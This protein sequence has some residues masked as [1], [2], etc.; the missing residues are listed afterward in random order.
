MGRK[1]VFEVAQPIYD[2]DGNL[3]GNVG[4]QI[5]EAAYDKLAGSVA[6]GAYRA[7]IVEEKAEPAAKDEPMPEPKKDEAK[8]KAS[9]AKAKSSGG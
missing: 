5:S 4:D 8:A 1:V 3:V 2:A 6:P 7:V 9:E